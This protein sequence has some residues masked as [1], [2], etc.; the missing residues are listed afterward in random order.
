VP[1]L[2]QARAVNN[3]TILLYW[4]IGRGIVEKQQT[5]GWGD[6]VVEMVA[7][8]LRHAFPGMRGFSANNVWLMRQFF[9]EY[10]AAGFLEH[11]VQEMGKVRRPILRQPVVELETG[12]I[13][14]QPVAKLN[15]DT[16][17]PFLRQLVA[18]I[19]WGQNLLILNKL[20][21]PAARLWYLY[22]TG[23]RRITEADVRQAE[24]GGVQNVPPLV[25]GLAMTGGTQ[26]G[27][28]HH[29]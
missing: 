18:E 13:W 23:Q 21:A 19:P 5:H 1:A 3:E 6:S 22:G 17:I 28:I 26:R 9:S 12:E 8:D 2:P 24:K 20:S 11:L 29:E 16:V 4:D 25:L 14:L 15:I 7:A 27:G 10:S